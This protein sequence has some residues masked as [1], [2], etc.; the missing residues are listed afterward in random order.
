ME[1]RWDATGLC[2]ITPWVLIIV[3]NVQGLRTKQTQI[4]NFH[5][6]Y[7]DGST[8]WSFPLLRLSGGANIT[9]RIV[10][11][12]QLENKGDSSLCTAMEVLMEAVFSVY[13][14]MRLYHVTEQ[15]QCSTVK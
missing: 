8:S 13:S 12:Q 6:I 10:A 4:N 1:A 11:R 7:V 5:K 15:V 3:L 9:N 2:L 14:T